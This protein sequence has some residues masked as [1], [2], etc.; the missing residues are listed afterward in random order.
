MHPWIKLGSALLQVHASLVNLFPASRQSKERDDVTRLQ[1]YIPP[2]QM[3]EEAFSYFHWRNLY[4]A[5]P[6]G[7]KGHVTFFPA[8]D[9]LDLANNLKRDYF[10]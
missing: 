7:E 6:Y 9:R 5:I 3:A 10:Y 2:T 8:S 1:L 4:S